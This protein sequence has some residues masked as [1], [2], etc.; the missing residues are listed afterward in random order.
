MAATSALTK[1]LLSWK[2]PYV[3]PRDTSEG[4]PQFRFR[5]PARGRVE[6]VFSTAALRDR[7]AVPR[8]SGAGDPRP[9]R[10]N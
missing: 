6:A 4:L 10:T 5:S 2:I 1:G 8:G 9:R 7:D 3:S